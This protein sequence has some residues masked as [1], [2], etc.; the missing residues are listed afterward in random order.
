[1]LISFNKEGVNMKQVKVI[2]EG[3][4]EE[5][6]VPKGNK[7]FVDSSYLIKE[8]K[9]KQDKEIDSIIKSMDKT[10]KKLVKKIK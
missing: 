8:Y 5:Y 1:M 7:I 10:N 9:K 2:I 6:K 4:N 3:S